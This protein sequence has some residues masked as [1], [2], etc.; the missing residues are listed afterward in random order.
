MK[1]TLLLLCATAIVGVALY[2]QR[3]PSVNV[4]AS[5]A[6]EQD[7]R[8]RACL[9]GSG[10]RPGGMTYY[11]TPHFEG[12]NFTDPKLRAHFE[13]LAEMLEPGGPSGK[14][15]LGYTLGFSP[16]WLY[17]KNG[18]GVWQLS[19]EILDK[20]LKAAAEL[21]RPFVFYLMGNHFTPP[22]PLVKEL[23][24]N[25]D[26][27]MRYQNG[28]VARES[29]LIGALAPFRLDPDENFPVT[30]YLHGASHKIAER[31]ADFQ[32][33][34]PDL[35]LGVLVN[36]E[37]HYLFSDFFSGT[38]NFY[39]PRTTDFSVA[40]KKDFY[41]SLKNEGKADLSESAVDEALTRADFGT[42]PHGILPV[43]GW[44]SRVPEGGILML[45][46]DGK[47]VATMRYGFSRTDVQEAKGGEF[48]NPGS[49]FAAWFDYSALPDGVHGVQAVLELGG[50]RYEIGRR[51]VVVGTGKGEAVFAPIPFLPLPLQGYLD[52]PKDNL[53][54]A[55]QP[56][57]REWVRFRE[58]RV[59]TYV[60]DLATIFREKGIEQKKIFSYQLSPWLIGS[61]NPVLFG[62][63]EDF[64][65]D[66]PYLPGM[67][68][69]GGNVRA[70][71]L[72][73][74]IEP[75]TVYGVPEFHP[76]LVGAKEFIGKS[77]DFHECMGAR[78]VSPY[79]FKLEEQSVNE[80]HDR[81][82][83]W[84]QNKVWGSDNFYAVLVEKL[85]Q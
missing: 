80:T 44:L 5:D 12:L 7:A 68:L 13:Q 9:D 25:D 16:Y 73:D 8:I 18:D 85:K 52:H 72:F 37:T 63:G 62:V 38:G 71:R 79:F 29:Y 75:G 78:F 67:N 34:Y 21:K 14:V 4:P 58:R 65:K 60:A 11:I 20:T 43:S 61:W 28:E 33:A 32:S 6:Q 45:Y 69:Y 59:K 1:K 3:P 30:R 56:L 49:G 26:L 48:F 82:R 42:M 77:L 70:A 17:W 84:P 27:L 55:Y 22:S 15:V 81:F 35:L 57:L 47:S 51:R 76:Q 10:A 46:V 31:L 41:R 74:M 40:E 66:A 39:S 24:Q 23:V 64:F 36:G 19:T 50:A 2:A 53:V 54:V 83:I